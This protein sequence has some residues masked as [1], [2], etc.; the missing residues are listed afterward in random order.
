MLQM[1]DKALDPLI[2]VAMPV[3]NAGSYL[4]LAVMSIVAQSYQ[5]WELLIID[6]KSTDSSLESIADI[7]DPRIR[8]LVS[9]CNQGLAARL[10]QAIDL[11]KGQFFARM[12]QDDISHP[13][14]FALQLQKLLSD[15]SLDLLGAQCITISNQNKI[16]G[17]LPPAESHDDICARPWLGFYLPHPTWMGRIAWFREHRY[18]TPGPYSCEDQELLLRT[19]AVSHFHVLPQRLLAY[20]VRDRFNWRKAWQT[21]ITLYKL[22]REYFNSKGQ[23]LNVVLAG[24]AVAMR[25]GIDSLHMLKQLVLGPITRHSSNAGVSDVDDEIWRKLIDQLERE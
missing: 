18:A 11:A 5:N 25:L 17:V 3:Y 15:P 6:D 19:Y 9:D 12:D 10:N 23:Y 20:R 14:R 21:R 2:T 24:L 16:F 4:R 8:I 13:E 22:H 7:Q 1:G